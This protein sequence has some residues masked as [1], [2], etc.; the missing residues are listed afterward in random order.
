MSNLQLP[1]A[2][3]L[4]STL[5]SLSL[6][7]ISSTF[8][9]HGAE[10][11][12][13]DS[14]VNFPLTRQ[15]IQDR[16]SCLPELQHRLSS[17]SSLSA[18]SSSSLLAVSPASKLSSSS[19]VVSPP[20]LSCYKFSFPFNHAEEG[21]HGVPAYLHVLANE[22]VI[23]KLRCEIQ[24]SEIKTTDRWNRVT[25]DERSNIT[26]HPTTTTVDSLKTF[27]VAL[28]SIVNCPRTQGTNEKKPIGYFQLMNTKKGSFIKMQS[29]I[30]R[31]KVPCIIFN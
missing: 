26:L 22:Q 24:I 11:K 30:P 17:S 21:E 1:S 13:D 20:V 4:S 7:A 23:G 10:E 16:F 18:S 2:L 27:S 3:S 19:L 31:S 8:S 9:S 28:Q 29:A 25:F 5:S 15:Q 12:S 6:S 14:G